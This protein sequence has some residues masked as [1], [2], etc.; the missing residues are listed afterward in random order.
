MEVD[1][2]QHDDFTSTRDHHHRRSWDLD[3]RSSPGIGGAPLLL[4]S[5]EE[6]QRI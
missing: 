6:K 5:W 2:I 4:G 3:R 1:L